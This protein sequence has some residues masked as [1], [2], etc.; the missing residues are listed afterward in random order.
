MKEN[1]QEIIKGENYEKILAMFVL[2]RPPY[3]RDTFEHSNQRA[4]HEYEVRH[5]D[6]MI[7]DDKHRPDKKVLEPVINEVTGMAAVDGKGNPKKKRATQ[8]VNRVPIAL[9]QVIVGRRVGFMLGNPIT[10]N[11]KYDDK[12]KKEKAVVEYVSMIEENAKCLYKNK[13]LA[14]RV[15]SEM[16]CAELWYLSPISENSSL[17]HLP[18]DAGIKKPAF[19]LKMKVLSPW[20]HDELYPLF[21]DVGDMV[22]FARKYKTFEDSN[23]IEHFDVYSSE[24][25][26]KYINRDGWGLDVEALN[27]GRIPNLSKKI[28]IIFHW[29]P[30]PEWA[31]VQKMIERLEKLLSNH[32]DMNDYFGEPILAIFG[33]LVNSIRKGESG[34]IMQLSKEAKASFLALDSPPESI[35]MEIDNLEKFIYALS[36]TPNISFQ[37]MKSLGAGDISGYAL[38]LL[39][40]DAHLA[41]RVKEE[42]FGVCI[43]RRVNLLKS[44]IGNV[45]DISLSEASKTVRMNPVFTPYLPKNIKEMLAMTGGAV[46]DNILSQQT[47]T[48]ILER[49]KYIPDA[50]EEFKRLKKE[51]QSANKSLL[52]E[53]STFEET[54]E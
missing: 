54:K 36:Q 40:L 5:H 6:V 10:Y 38:E 42:T 15:M 34:K 49:E 27:G 48:E 51:Q 53:T 8:K 39:F 1:Y 17:A 28:P 29:Q 50:E 12:N 19:E 32:G 31:N 26:Y 16:A 25:T 30:Q 41:V 3:L 52:G 21:D 23:E 24:M 44:F 45:L 13:E 4:K 7:D 46:N 43:Q 9:Q 35:K 18:S 33:Q 11:S 2:N 14:R 22:A 37:E 20:L 47:A